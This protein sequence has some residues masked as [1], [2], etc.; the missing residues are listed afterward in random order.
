[1]EG[2]NESEGIYMTIRPYLVGLTALTQQTPKSGDKKESDTGGYLDFIIDPVDKVIGESYLKAK[3]FI[4]S[5][6]K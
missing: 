3:E 6:M 1:M 2:Q 5:L 4:E